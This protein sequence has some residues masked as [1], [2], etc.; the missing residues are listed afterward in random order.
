M[1]QGY[2]LYDADAH[3]MMSPR[4]WQT[5]PKEYV[6]RR[7][8]PTRVSDVSDMGRWTNGWLIE[9]QIIP[10]ALGPGSQPGNEPA[11]V[12]KEFGASSTNDDFPLS[13]FDLSDP[14][15]RL[16]GLDSMGIDHQMLYPTTLYARMTSDPGFEAAL[17]RSYNR[18]MGRQCEAVSK[19]LKWAG[20]LPLRDPGQGCDAVEEMK[21]LGAT[22]AVVYGTAGDRLLCHRSFT[23]VWDELNRAGLPLC[24]H[25]GMSYP[26]FAEV[27]NGLLDAHGIG[28][29]LPAMMAFVAIVGHGMLDRYP[30]LKVGF[31]E[32]GAEWIFYMVGRLDH[33]LPIDRSQMPIKDEIPQRTIEEYVRSGRIFL[34]GEADDKMLVQ[35]IGLLGE[36]QILY[37]SDLPHGEGRHNAA[38]K[39]LERKDLT[40]TQK[41]KILYDNAV[42][43][44]GEP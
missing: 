22:A 35:E 3:A 20:L 24:V 32:F 27:C 42:K 6:A 2:L 15:A 23:P 31:L 34:A 16:R 4:M 41:R 18:Y 36:D 9:G 19:R 33:Y 38:R 29:S 5:L 12:L 10:H 28:M 13:S 7:P 25:M 40:D 39:I 44:F 17:F 14:E 37:S 8:R 43:F 21:K 11:R 1:L 30:D 26:P